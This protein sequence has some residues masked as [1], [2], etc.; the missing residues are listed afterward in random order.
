[1][2]SKEFSVNAVLNISNN[3][4]PQKITP[5]DMEAF[6]EGSQV[7]DVPKLDIIK[8]VVSFTTPGITDA[9]L[10]ATL[11]IEP[12]K[13][14]NSNYTFT[15]TTDVEGVLINGKEKTFTTNEFSVNLEY[16]ADIIESPLG[17]TI[18]DI[19]AFQVTPQSIPEADASIVKK[20]FK[21]GPTDVD[22]KDI[23]NNFKFKRSDKIAGHTAGYNIT[24][25][26]NPGVTINQSKD[27][28]TS[29]VVNVLIDFA[30][31]S[32]TA[33]D[34][35]NAI[36]QADLDTISDTFEDINV[37]KLAIIKKVFD[38]T[39]SS[40]GGSFAN[41]KIIAGLQVKKILK[42]GQYKLSLQKKSQDF[43]INGDSST[44]T[45][46]SEIFVMS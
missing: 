18:E 33:T 44:M 10:M 37:D 39:E 2:I 29:S 46:D 14:P 5:T 45:F 1:M 30:I 7:I 6:A 19:F 35:E 38:I 26:P 23:V 36:I 8:R 9:H 25:I 15:L 11:K 12:K 13:L 31:V 43:T 28:I 40:E 3:P 22:N 34:I 42:N 24:L 4:V 20:F 21:F 41:E 17:V 32:K 16:R 27:P